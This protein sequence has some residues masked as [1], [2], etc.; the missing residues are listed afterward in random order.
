MSLFIDRDAFTVNDVSKHR[1]ELASM[2]YDALNSLLEAVRS[3]CAQKCIPLDYGENDL[4]KGESECTNRCVNKF[5]SAFKH[6]GTY[7]ESGQRLTEKS[8]LHYEAVK[9]QLS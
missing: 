4:T 9:K 2:Q 5:M 7:V 6:I 3:S 1:L 8:L